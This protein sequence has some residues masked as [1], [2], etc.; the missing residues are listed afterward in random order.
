MFENIL[1][2]CI[3]NI[4]RSPMAEALLKDALKNQDKKYTIS[5]AGIGALVG[6][7][8]DNIACELMLEK[9]LD[10][11]DYRATQLN[12]D[13]I[14]KADLILVME[15]VHKE[16]IELKQPSAKGK[17][18]RLGHWGSFDIADPYRQERK[19]FEK[20]VRLI[21]KGVKDWVNKI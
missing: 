13:M 9:G 16:Q 12:Q 2:V 19:V 10:I 6:H 20:A 3:G 8:P 7:K 18:F 11:S 5:S 15:S 21:E 17:V 1:V 14:H 4:C